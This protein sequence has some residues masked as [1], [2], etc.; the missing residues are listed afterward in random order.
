MVRSFHDRLLGGVCGGLGEALPLPA[1]LWR[2]GFIL[3]TILTLG[4]GA[5]A[6]GL[7]WALWEHDSPV[8][9]RRGGLRGW[10]ALALAILVVLGWFFR[11]SMQAENGAGLYWPLILIL[12]AFIF[13]LSQLFRADGRPVWGVVALAL[14]ALWLAITLDH[15]PTG[16]QDLL[17][18][19]L[20]AGL[21]FLGLAM[22]LR[23]R[24]P[25]SDGIALVG[26]VAVAG[27]IASAGFAARSAEVNEGRTVQQEQNIPIEVIDLRLN[28]ATLQTDVRFE[29][30]PD[31]SRQVTATFTGSTSHDLAADWVAGADN[32]GT[33]TL[34]EEAADGFPTLESLGRGR[35]LARLPL[36]LPTHIA[37]TG[38]NGEGEFD[39][40]QIALERLQLDLRAGDAF[41]TLPDYQPLSPDID[42][43][44]S[45]LLLSAG[46][47]TLI[48]PESLGARF[49]FDKSVNRQPSFN[50]FDELVYRLEETPTTWVLESRNFASAEA[51]VTF[52]LSILQ[53]DVRIEI[54]EQA[55]PGEG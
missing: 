35:L 47:L 49:V 1:W 48:V 52:R 16:A 40:G 41:V 7:L 23:R 8:S 21:V 34:T 53:G 44:P 50:N 33:L 9:G 46:D 29:G 20:P 27:L 2:I 24:V 30:Q 26:A 22:A 6:Y 54:L 14:A 51:Q 4:A 32:T 28:I 3:L 36:D 13:L 43:N 12:L 18:R 42:A 25:F 39:L 11:D 19:L 45:H 15:V 17:Q 5:L 38:D 10:L 37:F 55:S 31:A